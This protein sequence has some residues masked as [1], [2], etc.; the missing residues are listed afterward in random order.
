MSEKK[1]NTNPGSNP[2]KQPVKGGKPKFSP[3]WIYGIIAIA[4]LGIQLLYSGSRTKKS[5]WSDWNKNWLKTR[6]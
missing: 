1:T 5:T 6:I 2:G 3:Y 4:I